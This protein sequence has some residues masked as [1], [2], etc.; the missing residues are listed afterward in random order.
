MGEYLAICTY[1]SH[2]VTDRSETIGN[3]RVILSE[4]SRSDAKSKDDFTSLSDALAAFA[5]TRSL[6]NT[7][8][9]GN[10]CS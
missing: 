8:F 5:D 2:F 7:L 9:K 10:T 4:S 3:Q 1:L 6:R